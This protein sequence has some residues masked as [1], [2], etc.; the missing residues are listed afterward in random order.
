MLFDWIRRAVR[1]AILAGVNEAVAELS[2]AGQEAKEVEPVR[3][4]LP[5]SDTAEENPE[6]KRRTKGG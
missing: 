2:G 1:N 4:L 3:L 5:Y 6:P